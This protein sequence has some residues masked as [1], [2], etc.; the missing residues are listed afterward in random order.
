[1]RTLGEAKSFQNMKDVKLTFSGYENGRL[2]G[3]VRGI[4]TRL[5]T[6]TR[7]PGQRTG[8]IMGVGHVDK[9]ANISFVIEFDVSVD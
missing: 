7:G 4:V 5:T 9:D 2:K 6:E 8:D 1:L 3:T